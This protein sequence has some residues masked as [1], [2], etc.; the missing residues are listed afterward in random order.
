MTVPGKSYFFKPK[1]YASAR[2]IVS[3]MTAFIS[4]TNKNA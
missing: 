3:G 2:S 1:K 4:G